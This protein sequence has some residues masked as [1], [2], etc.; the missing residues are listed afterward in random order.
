MIIL[1]P[2]RRAILA[3]VLSYAVATPVAAHLVWPTE[4]EWSAL[5]TGGGFYWDERRD[6]APAWIDLVGDAQNFSAGFWAY[7][8]DGHDDGGGLFSDAL[9]FRMRLRG[10]GDG[11]NTAWQVFIETDGNPNTVEWVLEAVGSGNPKQV[12][13]IATLTGGPRFRDVDTGKNQ[14]SWARP[15]SDY[16]RWTAVGDGTGDYFLDF[17]IPWPAFEAHTGVTSYEQL[18]VVLSTSTTHSGI[19]KDSPLGTSLNDSISD[20]LSD[21]IPEPATIGLLLAALFTTLGMRRIFPL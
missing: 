10:S 20:A 2:I 16:S 11:K 3:A 12:Q 4:S 9:L 18:R 19:N 14:P 1:L 7:V 8:V 17:G 21:A 15:I 5:T 13:L 6:Q